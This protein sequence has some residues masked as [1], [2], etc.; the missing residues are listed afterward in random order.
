MSNV[1]PPSL[2]QNQFIGLFEDISPKVSTFNTDNGPIMSRLKS[3]VP[4][5]YQ[6]TPMEL[7]G[8]QRTILDTFVNTTLR[9]GID[10]FEWT[11]F[12]TGSTRIFRLK[13]PPSLKFTL[14]NSA[15]LPDDRIYT[16]NLD[17]EVIT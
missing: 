1:W 8:A 11:D 9:G 2:P 5:R 7:T 6:S 15:I 14:A 17:L 16:A 4:D 12:T 10:S 3:T 13:Q